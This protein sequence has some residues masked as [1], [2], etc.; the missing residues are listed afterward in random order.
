MSDDAAVLLSLRVIA[1]AY[2]QEIIGILSH[3]DRVVLLQD[4]ADGCINRT[5]VLQFDDDGRRV[6]I[7]P[8]YQHQVGKPF[9]RC[10]LPVNDIVVLSI[11][12][13]QADD[14]SQGIL[15]VV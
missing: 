3:L 6:H 12:V 1:D 13:G 7:F 5:A 11:V 15:V 10:V 8:R 9:S 4:L 14:A 2:E